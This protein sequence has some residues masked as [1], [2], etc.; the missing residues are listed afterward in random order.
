MRIHLFLLVA[1]VSFILGG[2][3]SIHHSKGPV[4][5]LVLAVPTE[6]SPVEVRS[7]TIPFEYYH[8]VVRYVPHWSYEYFSQVYE[9]VS[10]SLNAF[11][12]MEEYSKGACSIVTPELIV[13]III[14][15]STGR[16]HVVSPYGAIGL[17]QVMPLHLEVLH[18]VGIVDSPSKDELYYTE[19]NIRAGIYVLMQ[20]A[21][22]VSTLKKA[23]ARYNAGPSREAKGYGYADRVLKL[24]SILNKGIGR[25]NHNVQL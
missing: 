8:Q 17:M 14:R 9:L 25:V 10:N 11:Q 21:K 6:D 3:Y 13:S 16:T 15:E 4:P 18:S 5:I 1:I 7:F 12:C 20:Y 23:L 22:K 24:A 2:T 19:K